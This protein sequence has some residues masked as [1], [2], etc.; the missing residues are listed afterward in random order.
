MLIDLGNIS[1]VKEFVTI[2]QSCVG[3]T[4]LKS[5][6]YIVDGKS[7]LGIFSLDLSK[8]IDLNIHAEEDV[9]KVA[10][11]AD[12]FN[13]IESFENIDGKYYLEKSEEMLALYDNIAKTGF[14]VL[15]NEA[16]ASYITTKKA[17]DEI[18]ASV[19][20]KE[21]YTAANDIMINADASASRL[22]WEN[23]YLGYQ[24]ADEAMSIVY[25][26]VA[27]K[28]AAAEKAMAEAKARAEAAAAFAVEA[29]EIAPLTE[30]GEAE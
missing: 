20:A 6:R 5:G 19:A 7:I 9:E 28:R 29:D 18:K 14:K 24:K 2:A 12:E 10:L 26:T 27:A 17:A 23:A 16:R 22:E 15:S 11:L 30:E 3:D 25:E 1:R 13:T 4:T 8:P 21:E